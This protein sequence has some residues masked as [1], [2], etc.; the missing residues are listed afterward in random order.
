MQSGDIVA[1][2]GTKGAPLP[3]SK[4]SPRIFG[5]RGPLTAS[6]LR[7]A[8]FDLSELRFMLDPGLL[9]GEVFPHLK[10]ERSLPGREIFI[11]HYRERD[12]YRG[13]RAPAN[14]NL[15]LVSVDCTAEE[16]GRAIARS[17]V[18]YSSS[19]HG[20]IFAHALGRP[21]VLV[22]PA[23]AE[24]ELKYR[25]YFASVGLSWSSPLPLVDA[26]TR[27]VPTLPSSVRDLIRSA[28]FPSIEELRAASIA[29]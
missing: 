20:V 24:P 10:N 16:L 3:S 8:G 28:D 12:T 2:L 15:R 21:A 7:E 29:D 22:A 19:L 23:T 26:V 5:V 11:P 4:V 27:G 9:I 6:A 1:G 18:V 13:Y 14:R 17:E 25:D